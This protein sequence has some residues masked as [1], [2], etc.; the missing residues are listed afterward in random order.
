MYFTYITPSIL[1]TFSYAYNSVLPQQALIIVVGSQC[2][3]PFNQYWVYSPVRSRSYCI[4]HVRDLLW[5]SAGATV[6]PYVRCQGTFS[7]C[8]AHPKHMKILAR[9]RIHT[10]SFGGKCAYRRLHIKV[11]IYMKI[12]HI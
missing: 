4:V 9:M 1:Q 12:V 3:M 10:A 11:Y 2:T 8:N 6:G 7:A 5:D